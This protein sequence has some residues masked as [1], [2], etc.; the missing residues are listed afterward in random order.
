M[1]VT[2]AAALAMHRGKW[3]WAAGFG[4]LAGLTRPVGVLF[5]VF[6]AVEV[7]TAIRDARGRDRVAQLATVAAPAIGCLSY[8]L[9]VQAR[10]DRGL[11]H[12]LRIHENPRLRGG[13]VNP[14]TNFGEAV[15]QLFSG[16]RFGSGLHAVTALVLVGLLVVLVRRWPWSYTAYAAA[17]LVLGL[18]ASNLDSLERYA[19]ST[20]P[21]VLAAATLVRS[22]WERVVWALCGAGMVALAVLVF[23]GVTVP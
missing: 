13:T 15:D 1:L 11:F 3:W 22:A 10:T 7:V 16:D 5:A 18:S 23:T 8:L 14:I 4:F 2:V 9:W 21:F 19:F 6:A 17:A 12:A 20:F